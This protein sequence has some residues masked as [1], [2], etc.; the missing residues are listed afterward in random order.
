M[1][2]LRITRNYDYEH[3]VGKIRSSV[4]LNQVVHE[5]ITAL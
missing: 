4:T 2:I 1:F 5:V 3:T